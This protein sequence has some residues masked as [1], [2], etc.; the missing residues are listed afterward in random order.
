MASVSDR[1]DD[2]TGAFRS[3]LNKKNTKR[4]LQGEAALTAN[5]SERAEKSKKKEK[6][7]KKDGKV[8][9]LKIRLSSR[10]SERRRRNDDDSDEERAANSDQEFESML[11]QYEKE[12]DAAEKAK[13]E[14]KAA[15][16]E[17]KK[18]KG[19][20]VYVDDVSLIL[21]LSQHIEF[22]CRMIIK[23]TVRGAVKVVRLFCAI[24]VHVR[25]ISCA[26]MLTQRHRQKATGVVLIV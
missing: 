22:A 11:R 10:K 8:E 7:G 26:G 6:G 16:K 13:A 15:K 14:R 23:T 2:E 12:Q 18:K 4:V 1:S 5:T 9:P 19:A 3:I 25:T 20:P 21:Q 24:R 17:A